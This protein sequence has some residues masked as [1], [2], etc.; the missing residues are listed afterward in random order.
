FKTDTE[1]FTI[2]NI[3]QFDS[4]LVGSIS[5]VPANA[6]FK[7][8]PASFSVGHLQKQE[9]TVTFTATKAGDY[10]AVARIA[11]NSGG[12]PATNDATLMGKRWADVV[13]G[14]PVPRISVSPDPM[15]FFAGVGKS[16]TLKLTVTNVGDPGSTL[17]GSVAVSGKGFS[18]AGNF[19][20]GAG[21]SEDID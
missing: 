9:I 1:T 3:G 8:N 15:Q 5:I 6:P 10:P 11:S 14:K 13:P 20:L 21:Q 4:V 18:G 7:V 17:T 12:G 2:Q 16:Q 19:S